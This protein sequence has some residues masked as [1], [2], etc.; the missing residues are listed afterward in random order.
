MGV[1]LVTHQGPQGDRSDSVSTV[2]QFLEV[3]TE[4][5]LVF[6]QVHGD[7]GLH[8]DLFG[9]GLAVTAIHRT[10]GAVQRV[11]GL[12]S[13]AV[14]KTAQSLVH[15]QVIRNSI[16]V[17]FIEVLNREVIQQV[18][19]VLGE[20]R[21]GV[22][23]GIDVER[24]DG[25]VPA[26]E[27]IDLVKDPRNGVNHNLIISFDRI[28]SCLLGVELAHI[29][30][31]KQAVLVLGSV[32]GA[33]HAGIVDVDVI[34]HVLEDVFTRGVGPDRVVQTSVQTHRSL[35]GNGVVLHIEQSVGGAPG[36]LFDIFVRTADG[37][38]HIVLLTHL[39][40]ELQLSEV[41]PGAG[42]LSHAAFVEGLAGQVIALL[43]EGE[44]LIL[45]IT[46]RICDEGVDNILVGLPSA[47]ASGRS[48]VVVGDLTAEEEADT[49]RIV[50]LLALHHRTRQGDGGEEVVVAVDGTS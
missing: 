15:N 20:N 29:A 32:G 41:I 7:A 36:S 25:V 21:V 27:D 14:T 34:H 42:I 44:I 35:S 47:A 23:F 9:L 37:E 38:S 31:F 26:L 18:K 17:V 5:K 50:G 4:L 2:G 45:I 11:N 10:R 8:T 49:G 24:D 46:Q 48:V 6:A 16:T 22:E 33:V 40:V 39:E 19:I 3:I 43:R 13:V 28:A 1:G 30:V 12:G